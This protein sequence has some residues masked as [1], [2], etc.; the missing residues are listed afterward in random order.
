MDTNGNSEDPSENMDLLGKA[1]YAKGLLA[2][3]TSITYNN[4]DCCFSVYLS[5]GY[6]GKNPLEC[7]LCAGA[8][9]ETGVQCTDSGGIVSPECPGNGKQQRV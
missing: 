4:S 9:R 8:D 2:K 6:K 7:S 5:I 1:A 3:V